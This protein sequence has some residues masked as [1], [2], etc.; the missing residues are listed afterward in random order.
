MTDPMPQM[1]NHCVQVYNAMHKTAELVQNGEG[2]PRRIWTGFLTKLI[3]EDCK[4]AVPYFTGVRNN[5]MRMGCIAQITRGGGTHPSIWELITAP[6]EE[7][8]NA[9]GKVRTNSKAS[10]LQGQLAD[11]NTRLERVE[12]M[13]ANLASEEAS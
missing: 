2:P 11:V 13:L 3:N 12:R 10:Q 8:F 1:F 5:L 4:L 7:L 9:K 6:T